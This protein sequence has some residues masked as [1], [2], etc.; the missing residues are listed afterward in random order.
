MNRHY[1]KEDTQMANKYMKRCSKSF[2]STEVQVKTT[3]RCTLHPPGWLVKEKPRITSV[4]KDAKK[5]EHP[6][7][8]GRDVKWCSLCG[9]QSGNSSKS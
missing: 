3:V 9:K 8:A 5:L 7:T 4:G 2:D 1:S 6:C